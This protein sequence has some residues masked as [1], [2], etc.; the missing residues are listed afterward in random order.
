[1]PRIAQPIVPSTIPRG[2]SLYRDHEFIG[3]YKNYQSST[4][5]D[6]SAVLRLVPSVTLWVQPF[7]EFTAYELY[8]SRGGQIFWLDI[9]APGQV[10]R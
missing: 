3:L 9:P 1:M 10:L 8:S 6:G 2:F 4:H 5:G 7:E